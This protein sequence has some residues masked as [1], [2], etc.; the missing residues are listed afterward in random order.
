MSQ[1]QLPDG[2][3]MPSMPSYNRYGSP[4]AP[5]D[6]SAYPAQSNYPYPTTSKGYEK[7]GENY[8]S[9]YTPPQFSTQVANPQYSNPY[10]AGTHQNPTTVTDSQNLPSGSGSHMNTAVNYNQYNNMQPNPYDQY[11]PHGHQIA[12]IPEAVSSMSSYATGAQMPL[13]QTELSVNFGQMQIA[14]KQEP[15]IYTGE[16]NQTYFNVQHPHTST[17]NM[18]TYSNAPQNANTMVSSQMPSDYT[19]LNYPYSTET[20]AASEYSQ[21]INPNVSVGYSAMNQPAMSAMYNTGQEIKP[22]SNVQVTY[23]VSDQPNSY[24]GTTY[25][26]AHTYGQTIY[27]NTESV[28]TSITSV[29]MPQTSLAEQYTAYQTEPMSSPALSHI[30]SMDQPIKSHVTGEALSTNLNFQSTYPAYNQP[31]LSISNST[32]QSSTPTYAAPEQAYPQQPQGYQSDNTQNFQTAYAFIDQTANMVYSQTFQNHPGYSYNSASGG[33][34]YHYGSQNTHNTSPAA[35]YED[36]NQ[37]NVD[38]QQMSQSNQN[39]STQGTYTSAGSCDTL[40]SPSETVPA[41][42]APEQ[43]INDQNNQMYYNTP[44]GYVTNTNQ[45]SEVVPNTIEAS[46]NYGANINQ[47]TYMQSGQRTQEQNTNVTYSNNQGKSS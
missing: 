23:N 9:P 6:L 36:S 4:Y 22:V 29:V 45:S 21:G 12:P 34:D 20:P 13:G 5:Q 16:Y 24:P 46:T 37:V 3:V 17:P 2:V 25:D 28:D 38:S 44:Y 39:W 8:S 27:T 42:A 11:V 1:M 41:P 15:A 33:Y 31:A 19:A 10:Y 18:A 32:D 35:N 7:T 43:Q 14:P 30:D 47:A 40:Q 26:M